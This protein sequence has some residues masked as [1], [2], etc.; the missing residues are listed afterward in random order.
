MNTREICLRIIEKLF[1]GYTLEGITANLDN[2]KKLNKKDNA[3]V[4][5]LVLTFLRRN[6]EVD[7]VI[8]KFVK[9]P[10][11]GKDEKLKNILRIGITQ[12]L[13][14]EFQI[15]QQLSLL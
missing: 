15:M 5:M 13:F 9:K 11:K 8:N 10:L 12:I 14:L 3:F 2:F 4:K 7:F 1:Q 6:G